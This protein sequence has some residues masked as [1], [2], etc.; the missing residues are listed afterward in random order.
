MKESTKKTGK[1][2]IMAN[3][4]INKI[5]LSKNSTPLQEKMAKAN[6]MLSKITNTEALK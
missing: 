2:A 5:S 4:K 3:A 1:N 6:D